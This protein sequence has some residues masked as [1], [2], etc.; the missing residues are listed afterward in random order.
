ML[1]HF[2]LQFI[3]DPEK[4]HLLDESI[5]FR[6]E[7]DN[8]V[9]YR[10]SNG[11]ILALG[12]TGEEARVLHKG[13]FERGAGEVCSTVL[14]GAQ[15]EEVVYE[16][17][18]MEEFTRAYHHR[19][20]RSK[21]M[22]HFLAKLVDGFDYVMTIPGYDTFAKARQSKLEQ[23]LQ[24]HLRLRRLV[25]NGREVQI[26]LWRR[27]LEFWTRRLL[28]LV[29]PVAAMMV[30]YWLMPVAYKSSPLP[31]LATLLFYPGVVYC[32]GK[33]LW[34][35]LARWL[36]PRDYRLCMLQGRRTEI[37]RADLFLASLLWR[38]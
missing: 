22:A 20:Q 35:L 13:E 24:A 8:R 2:E 3:I 1:M 36:V 31:F 33:I 11:Q 15:G 34:M 16:V 6:L 9:V 5:D 4:I 30:A 19:A 26:P 10:R 18:M 38:H 28:K 37:P 23:T 27:N 17:R 14:F 7:A 29:M 32:A 12:G 21:P 25:I